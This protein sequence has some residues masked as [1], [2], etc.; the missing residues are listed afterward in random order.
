MVIPLVFIY[1]MGIMMFAAYLV[2]R[3]LL[4]RERGKAVS[5][6]EK[7]L[8]GL[9]VM[10]SFWVLTAAIALPLLDFLTVTAPTF[11][12]IIDEELSPFSSFMIFIFLITTISG[13]I[14]GYSDDP[15]ARYPSA[16]IGEQWLWPLAVLFAVLGIV[17]ILT[18]ILA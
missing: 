14:A 4:R 16:P 11:V 13:L 2:T 9:N 17:G 8:H 5:R 3:E 18:G 7:H 1:V 6:S 15:R 10:S 12:E